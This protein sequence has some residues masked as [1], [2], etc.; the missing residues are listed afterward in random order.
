MPPNVKAPLMSEEH[1]QSSAFDEFEWDP[2]QEGSKKNK[3]KRFHFIR[4]MIDENTHHTYISTQS[5]R[6]SEKSTKSLFGL[7]ASAELHA[8]IAALPNVLFLD[9]NPNTLHGSIQAIINHTLA[10]YHEK[11]MMKLL[12]ANWRKW[13]KWR[14]W[15]R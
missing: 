5:M 15:K 10:K 11:N 13:I 9:V 7:N 14:K 2:S 1:E 4:Q 3:A 8:T 6:I 12:R